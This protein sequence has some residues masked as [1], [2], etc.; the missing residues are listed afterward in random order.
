MEI[1]KQI[2]VEDNT[3][4]G[5]LKSTLSFSHQQ[6]HYELVSEICSLLSSFDKGKI[7]LELNAMNI[8]K[9][10]ITKGKDKG[11]WGYIGIQIKQEEETDM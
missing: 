2:D 8:F 7:N 1:K 9:K 4:I 3:L 5:A 10:K 6:E 11:K